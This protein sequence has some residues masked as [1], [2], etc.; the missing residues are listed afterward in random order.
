RA[1]A[2]SRGAPLPAW[3]RGRDEMTSSPTPPRV[4]VS[5]Q[6]RFPGFDLARELH[7]LG[8]LQRLMAS[9][10]VSRVMQWKI[11]REKIRSTMR[12]DALQRLAT[13]IRVDTRIPP[14]IH[15]TNDAFDRA[16]ARRV[17][18]A[19]VV[20]AWPGMALHTHRRARALG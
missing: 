11:P 1:Q 4:V 10:P 13:G 18:P 14:F 5:L 7:A 6:G 15:V 17:E 12:Y 19:D 3:R 2:A 20:V 16:I 8:L 9:Q